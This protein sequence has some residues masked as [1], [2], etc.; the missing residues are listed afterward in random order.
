VPVLTANSSETNNEDKF[1]LIW[2]LVGFSGVVIA[3]SGIVIF[4]VIGFTAPSAYL[5]NAIEYLD[6]QNKVSLGWIF[7]FVGI[8]ILI[9]SPIITGLLFAIYEKLKHKHS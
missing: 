1:L 4:M 8:I 6:W 9:T 7:V 3:I 5:S 2:G